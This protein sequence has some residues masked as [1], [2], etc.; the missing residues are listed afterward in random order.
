M[1]LPLVPPYFMVNTA[2]Q[3]SIASTPYS[4]AE[5]TVLGGSVV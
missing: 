3:V 4:M 5:P 1:T 2:I